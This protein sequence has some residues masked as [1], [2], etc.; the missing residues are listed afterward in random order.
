MLCSENRKAFKNSSDSRWSVSAT[1]V[2]IVLE[3]GVSKFAQRKL[4]M[5]NITSVMA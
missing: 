4:W 2:R 5:V 1:K 3:M